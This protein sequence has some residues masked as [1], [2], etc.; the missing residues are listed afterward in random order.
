MDATWRTQPFL[1]PGMSETKTGDAFVKAFNASQVHR[2]TSG[3]A[4]GGGAGA[5]VRGDRLEEL[6][7]E[8]ERIDRILNSS[9]LPTG[10]ALESL[11]NERASVINQIAEHPRAAGHGRQERCGGHQEGAG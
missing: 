2:T 3:S 9:R 10:P 8:R 11:L 4:H 1:P 5:G 7:A 6:I